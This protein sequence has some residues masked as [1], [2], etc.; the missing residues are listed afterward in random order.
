MYR[1]YKS[2][3]MVETNLV[4]AGINL[5]SHSDRSWSLGR[6]RR[7]SS[8]LSSSTDR[9]GSQSTAS[10]PAHSWR[11]TTTSPGRTI[12]AGRQQT[13]LLNFVSGD[14]APLSMYET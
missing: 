6:A 13:L 8:S 1:K 5:F 3:F 4:C 12:S 7:A 2:V 11:S 14:Q 9:T 10:R